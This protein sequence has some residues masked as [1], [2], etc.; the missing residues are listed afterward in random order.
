MATKR[1]AKKRVQNYY[2]P[3]WDGELVELVPPDIIEPIEL[4][5]PDTGIEVELIELYTPELNTI[6]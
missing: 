6:K 1:K 2:T 3:F 5:I 4:D